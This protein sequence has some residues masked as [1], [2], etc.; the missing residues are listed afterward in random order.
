[1]PRSH[2][3]EMHMPRSHE[4]EMHMPRSHEEEM[5]KMTAVATRRSAGEERS[6]EEVKVPR[7]GSK[8]NLAS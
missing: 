3:E 8:G 2:E 7:P 4:E 5:P 6:V 1:M